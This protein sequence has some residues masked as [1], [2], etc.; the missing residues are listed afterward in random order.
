MNFFYLTLIV[1]FFLAFAA[2]LFLNRKRKPN[3]FWSI[4]LI[5]VFV[6]IAGLRR[7]IGDTGEYVHLFGLV[8]D[9]SVTIAT[10][11]FEVGF[12]L[13]LKI[14]TYI[15]TDPQIMIF[16]TSL[17]IHTCNIWTLRAY[18]SLFE[19]QTYIYIASGFFLTLMNG[20]R[21]GMAA[22]VVFASTKL[23]IE[24][25]FKWYLAVVL[26]MTTV[27]TSALIMIPVYFIVRE[28]AW[29]KRIMK[30]ILFSSIA[31]LLAQPLIS[32]LF[33]LLEGTRYG[34]YSSFNE[35]GSS[36]LRTVIAA[37]PV[38][39]AYIGRERLKEEWPESNVF[40][41]MSIINLIIYS[42]SLVN[43]IFAR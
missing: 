37:I 23:I 22:A 31:L 4:L 19:L 7:G 13:F 3:L 40:V 14:L 41:N 21:Q 5:I 8:A 2:R 26:V 9:G 32:I 35:G 20:M 39:L 30:I 34:G 6:S 1:T 33:Q 42:F 38:V 11:G 18:A 15:S 24:N 27:H 10:E 36:I 16:V 28:T 43:W 12:I 29:S 17:I 25:K